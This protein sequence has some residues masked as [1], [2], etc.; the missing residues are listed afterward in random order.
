VSIALSYLI[1]ISDGPRRFGA[2]TGLL[3]VGGLVVAV[4]TFTA[5]VLSFVW[6]RRQAAV[7]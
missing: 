1:A 2:S 6:S 3:V 7:A 4:V 5:L